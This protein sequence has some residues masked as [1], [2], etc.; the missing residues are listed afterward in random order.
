MSANLRNYYIKFDTEDKLSDEI[1]V[2]LRDCMQ[3]M[4]ALGENREKLSLHLT[5]IHLELV[6]FFKKN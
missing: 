6:D 1:C 3:L 4:Q 2:V 5:N